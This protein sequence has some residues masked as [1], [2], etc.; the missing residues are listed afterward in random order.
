MRPGPGRRRDGARSARSAFSRS[1][2]RARAASSSLT[3]GSPRSARPVRRS[4]RAVAGRGEARSGRWQRRRPRGIR[5]VRSVLCP[6]GR[7]P[8][9]LPSRGR[10]GPRGASPR[11]RA[12]PRRRSVTRAYCRRLSSLKR[13]SSSSWW[14]R[15][16]LS[17]SR[18]RASACSGLRR[19]R[20]FPAQAAAVGRRSP[21]ILPAS[22]RSP[23]SRAAAACRS[24]AAVNSLGSNPYSSSATASK[25]AGAPPSVA[26]VSRGAVRPCAAAGLPPRTPPTVVHVRSAKCAIAAEWAQRL[27]P[28]PPTSPPTVLHV[29]LVRGPLLEVAFP[30]PFAHSHGA[31]RLRHTL[32]LLLVRT[33][34]GVA[35]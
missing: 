6:D 14:A 15:R 35:G 34:V 23:A 13:A 11:P 32:Q 12:A 2:R 5:P 4:R 9:S 18:I 30:P 31:A 3:A 19:T 10:R 1:R 8:T 20:R 16:R 33:Q 27:V 24:R 26:G 28:A 29:P 22:A 17:P 7:Q 21:L 25:S